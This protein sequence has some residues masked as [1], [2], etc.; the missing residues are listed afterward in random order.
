MLLME[1]LL[2]PPLLHFSKHIVDYIN[3]LW[4]QDFCYIMWLA[5]IDYNEK[6]DGY[7]NC[8]TSYFMWKRQRWPAQQNY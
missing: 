5:R 6:S 2:W 8:K 4:A 7:I 1:K 3:W